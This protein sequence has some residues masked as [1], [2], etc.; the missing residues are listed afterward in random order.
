LAGLP[1]EVLERA[2][3][4]SEWMREKVKTQWVG[5]LARRL[6]GK[7]F[8]GKSFDEDRWESRGQRVIEALREAR[9]SGGQLYKHQGM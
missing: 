1:Q 4:Q 8:G 3:R 5:K 7:V 6:E 9:G 2:D